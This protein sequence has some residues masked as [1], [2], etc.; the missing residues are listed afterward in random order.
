MS[1]AGKRE[2]RFYLEKW[3]LMESTTTTDS[4]TATIQPNHR[5]SAPG[6][7]IPG[8]IRNPLSSGRCRFR[9][10]PGM[11]VPGTF[12]EFINLDIFAA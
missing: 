11:T 7:V 2:W 6:T 8:L 9:I 5:H 12:Y 1:D 3:I 4:T 10:K